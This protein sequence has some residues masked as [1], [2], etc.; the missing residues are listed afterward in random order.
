[1]ADSE[2]SRE[3]IPPQNETAPSGPR[4]PL[5]LGETGWRKTLVRGAKKFSRDRCSMTAGSLAYHWFLAL[6]PALIAVLGITSLLRLGAGTIKHL[7]DGL[8]TA[9]PPGAS[10]VFADAVNSATSRSSAASLTALIIGVVVALW[11]ASAG[12]A[13]LQ[14]G[15]NIAYEVPQDRKFVATRLRSFPLMAVTA[16]L[17]GV[18]AVLLVFGAPLGHAI[19]GHVGV[20]GS[21]FVVVWTIVRWVATLIVVSLLFSVY[22]FYAPNRPS[23]RWQWVSPGGLVGTAI[24]LLASLG[25]SFYVAKFGSYGKTYGAFAGVVILIFWLYL[26]AIAVLIGAEINAEAEREAA[27]QSGDP[28]ARAGAAEVDRQAG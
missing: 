23:P 2:Q 25:F 15:L 21:A 27:V 22:Y 6:F 12:M 11:S 20:A 17:G 1:M 24:F 28:Q 14:T 19:E 13:A 10:G 9:L 26:A 8:N 5:D 4:T 7:V 3:T 16:L 18:A